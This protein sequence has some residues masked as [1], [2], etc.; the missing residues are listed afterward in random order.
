MLAQRVSSHTLWPSRANAQSAGGGL[1]VTHITHTPQGE[2]KALMF[3][4]FHRISRAKSLP[5]S[6]ALKCTLNPE[7]IYAWNK[8]PKNIKSFM[9]WYPCRQWAE[10]KHNGGMSCSAVSG[11][12]Y[13]GT[14][15][16]LEPD[17]IHSLLSHQVRREEHI[18]TASHRY[19][20]PAS[21]L[22][23]KL[24]SQSLIPHIWQCLLRGCWCV[25]ACGVHWGALIF[26]REVLSLVWNCGT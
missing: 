17:I 26:K 18:S 20:Q 13:L 11:D 23:E 15:S 8:K 7:N 3:H 21:C 6:K 24:L 2:T 5:L 25:D 9:I 19:P 22:G 1:S 10:K 16:P 12:E 14:C 4:R